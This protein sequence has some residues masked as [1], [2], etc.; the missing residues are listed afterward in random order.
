MV[1]VNVCLGGEFLSIRISKACL[2]LARRGYNVNAIT[3]MW[4][5]GGVGLSRYTSWLANMLG[6]NN[7]CMFDPSIF[8]DDNELRK[9]IESMSGR[10]VYTG[11]ERP[12]HTKQKMRVDVVK[13][14]ATAE[15]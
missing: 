1:M 11:Q 12:T 5:P 7:H 10:I 8:F 14:V 15:G 9:R 13:K 2:A 6:D 4:G 3:L